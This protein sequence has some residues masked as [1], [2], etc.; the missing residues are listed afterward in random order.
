L[1][2]KGS[3]RFSNCRP[4]DLD[5]SS[6]LY[7]AELLPRYVYMRVDEAVTAQ[8]ANGTL[9]PGTRLPGERAMAQRYGVAVSTARRAVE[10]LRRRSLV[11]TLPAKGTYVLPKR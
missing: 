11:V 9:Q 1:T 10:E 8:I 3:S 4:V 7:M 2:S 6:L 5:R